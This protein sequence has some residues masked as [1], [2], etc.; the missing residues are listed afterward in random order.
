MFSRARWRRFCTRAP[1]PDARQGHEAGDG[2]HAGSIATRQ[3]L[4]E[5]APTEIAH[6]F[7]LTYDAGVQQ[8]TPPSSLMA[9][10]VRPGGTSFRASR[11]VFG[12]HHIRVRA[13]ALGWAV[14]SAILLLNVGIAL[15]LI[16]GFLLGETPGIARQIGAGTF[17]VLGMVCA[18]LV[19]PHRGVTFDLRAGVAR[20][21]QR[22]IFL[23]DVV[24]IQLLAEETGGETPF[25]SYELNLVF[26]PSL[27]RVNVLDHGSEQH[28]LQDATRLANLLRVPVW[29]MRAR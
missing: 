13:T 28:A 11:L 9:T 17:L 14:A 4:A 12:E 16:Q 27:E 3:E 1:A 22:V 10:A 6:T 23:R 7:P 15:S 20:G 25:T 18:F 19:L 5:L 26:G 29:R 24:G 2:L 8:P 21:G